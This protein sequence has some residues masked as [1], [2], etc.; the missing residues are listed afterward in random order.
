MRKLL[1]DPDPRLRKICSEVTRIDGS[2]KELVKELREHIKD[3]I[4]G[5]AAPQLGEL[6]QVFVLDLK[7]ISLVMINPRIIYEKDERQVIE[8]CESLPGRLFVLKRPK[9]IKIKGL[10]L[11]G[12]ERAVKGRDF[13]AQ[14][15][16]HEMGHLRGILVDNEA[17]RELPPSLVKKQNWWRR[18]F[19]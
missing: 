7:N 16:R 14:V 17:V 19:G 4:I 8:G 3:N 6:I 15:L 12:E 11:E 1:L 9:L 2:I 5:L 10:N 13:L 18:A